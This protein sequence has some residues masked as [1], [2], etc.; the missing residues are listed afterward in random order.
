MKYKILDETDPAG[1]YYIELLEEPFKGVTY[2][3]GQIDVDE[4]EEET[5]ALIKFQYSLKMEYNIKNLDE[6][7]QTLG[8]ILL[9]I[10]EEQ[11]KNDEVVYHGGV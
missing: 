8:N 1:F 6:F 5:E 3:Y 7:R 10:L 2:T 4:N 11:V 9:E